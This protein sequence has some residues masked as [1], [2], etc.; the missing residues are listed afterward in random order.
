MAKEKKKNKN[1]GVAHVMYLDRLVAHKNLQEVI[2]Q[3]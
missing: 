3:L 2:K 1:P